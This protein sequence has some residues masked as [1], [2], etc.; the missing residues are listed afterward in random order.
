MEN[1]SVDAIKNPID[2]IMPPNS[3]F[4]DD[5]TEE[6]KSNFKGVKLEDVISI[7][8]GGNSYGTAACQWISDEILKKCVNLKKV[9][10]SDMFT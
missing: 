10:F 8:L 7:T 6:L 4:F 2:F 3:K 1:L 9:N 5:A